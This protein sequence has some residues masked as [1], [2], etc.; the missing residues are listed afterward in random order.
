MAKLTKEIL[1]FSEEVKR[2]EVTVKRY[3]IGRGFIIEEELNEK[4]I[5]YYVYNEKYGIKE[6]VFGI[7]K[8]HIEEITM[9]D[10]FNI[11][12]ELIDACINY[13]RVYMET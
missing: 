1:K 5:I 2:E 11:T 13:K 4:E 3:H 10:E 9:M 6:H 12:D 8:E 7:P